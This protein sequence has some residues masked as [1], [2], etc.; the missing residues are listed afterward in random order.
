MVVS[1]FQSF[2]AYEWLFQ[3][4]RTLGELVVIVHDA[5]EHK[6]S[7]PGFVMSP[8]A[9]VLRHAHRL[10]T[11][12]HDGIRH[13]ERYGKAVSIIPFPPMRPSPFSIRPPRQSGRIGFLFI[14]HIKPEKGLARL[15]RVWKKLPKSTLLK[16]NLKIAGSLSDGETPDFAGLENASFETGFLAED[17]FLTVLGEADCLIFPYVGGTSSG[18]YSISCSLGKPSI[19]SSLPV[20]SES[21]FYPA[22][23][24][25][26]DDE[27]LAACISQIVLQPELLRERE[28]EMS[29]IW[30]RVESEFDLFFERSNPFFSVDAKE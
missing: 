9:K 14:G 11:H 13:L 1:I 3:R 30:R 20:F 4:L 15:L 28:R 24:S 22:S 26:D 27:G 5:V 6:H 19:V 25:F 18:V 16:C 17:R 10:I 21:P 12:S 2:R 23:F 29:A 7:Y 8:R